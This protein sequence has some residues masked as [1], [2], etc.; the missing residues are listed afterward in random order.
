[1]Y[2]IN[3]YL[4]VCYL[5][6]LELFTFNSVREFTPFSRIVLFKYLVRALFTQL[7]VL[8]FFKHGPS[9]ERF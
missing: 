9:V 1:M 8:L 3:Y 6:L 4:L 7:H 2:L 5:E